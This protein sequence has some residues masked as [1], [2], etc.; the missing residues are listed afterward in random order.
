MTGHE[1]ATNMHANGITHMQ[2]RSSTTNPDIK[3][4]DI[5]LLSF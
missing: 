2:Y 4:S 5:L 3:S 1:R